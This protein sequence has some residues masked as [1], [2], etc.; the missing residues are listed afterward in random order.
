MKVRPTL[1]M[2]NQEKFIHYYEESLSK[3]SKKIEVYNMA[4]DMW[5]SIH[6]CDPPYTTFNSFKV[7]YSLRRKKVN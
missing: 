1:R 7:S 2:T 5:K 6:S 4:V 3:A